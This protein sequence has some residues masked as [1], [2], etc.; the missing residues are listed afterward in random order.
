MFQIIKQIFNGSESKPLM[1]THMHIWK[2]KYR[3]ELVANP[4]AIPL[5]MVLDEIITKLCVT[6]TVL[7]VLLGMK[8]CLDP[9]RISCWL[10]MATNIVIEKLQAHAPLILDDH[11]MENHT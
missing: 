2:I 1:D 9:I 3:R 10:N 7:D 8:E 11:I 4:L 5:P 6:G